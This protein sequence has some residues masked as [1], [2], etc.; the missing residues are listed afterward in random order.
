MPDDVTVV[1]IPEVLGPPMGHPVELYVESNDDTV[2]RQAAHR[3]SEWLSRI[4]GI[5]NIDVDERPGPFQIDL[6][7]DAERTALRRVAPL[8][9]NFPGCT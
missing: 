3:I 7:L 4:E 5:S 9:E 1:F 8:L 6:N 2:R